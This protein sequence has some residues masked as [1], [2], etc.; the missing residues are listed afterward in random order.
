MPPSPPRSART[1]SRTGGTRTTS[2]RSL[3]NLL[4]KKLSDDNFGELAEAAHLRGTRALVD[5]CV[6]YAARS[7][8]AQAAADAGE[9]SAAVLELLGGGAGRRAEPE[10]AAAS[11]FDVRGGVGE[12][13]VRVT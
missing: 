1:S 8:A 6:S 7:A 3:E 5:A 12:R 2:S 4:A 11:R 9:Y 10:E 13:A